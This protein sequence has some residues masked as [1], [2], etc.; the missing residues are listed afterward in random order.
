MYVDLRLR[1]LSASHHAHRADVAS[2]AG[3]GAGHQ[4]LPSSAWPVLTP[5]HQSAS[6]RDKYSD[7]ARAGLTSR[8]H[9]SVPIRIRGKRR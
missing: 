4:A 2:R 8:C 9:T 6:A 7:R 1:V 5:L 3:D